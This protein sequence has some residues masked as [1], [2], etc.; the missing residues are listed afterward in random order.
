VAV[1][2]QAVAASLGGRTNSTLTQHALLLRKHG[3]QLPRCPQPGG[4][5]SRRMFSDKPAASAGAGA[6]ATQPTAMQRLKQMSAGSG[7]SFRAL[8][9]TTGK[10]SQTIFR[11]L[12]EKV[13]VY[14]RGWHGKFCSTQRVIQHAHAAWRHALY[15]GQAMGSRGAAWAPAE[16]SRPAAGGLLAAPPQQSAGCRRR[17][18]HLHPVVRA[19]GFVSASCGGRNGVT[20]RQQPGG[21][22]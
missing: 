4:A 18:T 15:I 13:T 16:G 14:L 1:S 6:G 22:G 10:T 12:P 2:C 9:Q 8:T 21:G 5:P 11:Q 3:A 7:S 17:R 20:G 19:P